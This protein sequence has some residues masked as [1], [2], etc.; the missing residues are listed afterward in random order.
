CPDLVCTVFCENGFKKDENG[1]DI[2]QCAKPE[3][4]EVMCDVYCE[5]G[6]KKNEN[7]CDICQCA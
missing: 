2:C 5:N 3:C 1:C 7:G 4:P 6:F